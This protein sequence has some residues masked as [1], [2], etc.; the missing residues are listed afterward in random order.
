[1]RDNHLRVGL[2]SEGSRLEQRNAV[3]DAHL[4]YIE[5]GLDVIDS[6]YNE[7]ETLPELIIENTFCAGSHQGCVNL[8]V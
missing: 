8:D 5:A 4:V 7:V 3:E 6:V 2:A 1:M